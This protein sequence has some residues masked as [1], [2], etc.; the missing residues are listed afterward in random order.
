MLSLG[1]MGFAGP[2]AFASSLAD[3]RSSPLLMLLSSPALPTRGYAY[4]RISVA[5]MASLFDAAIAKPGAEA[6]EGPSIC[7]VEVSN[8][9]AVYLFTRKGHFAHR[10]VLTRRIVQTASGRAIEVGGSTSVKGSA[11]K[12]W[13]MQ[14]RTEDEAVR[15]ALHRHR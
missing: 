8:E 7:T 2:A 9:S 11:M 13:L 12:E 15:A 3:M 6:F 4:T 10:S 14:F 5:S 1:G